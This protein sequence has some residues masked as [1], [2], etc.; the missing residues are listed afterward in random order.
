[1]NVQRFLTICEEGKHG[2]CFS[3]SWRPATFGGA[4]SSFGVSCTENGFDYINS[5]SAVSMIIAQDPAGTTPEKT[6]KLCMV[7]NSENQTDK[8]ARNIYGLWTAAVSLGPRGDRPPRYYD[9]NYSTNA[10]KHGVSGEQ[11]KYINKARRS[12]SAILQKEIGL[13]SPRVII[14]CGTM[15]AQS[16]YEIGLITTK[17]G[18]FRKNLGREVY[19]ET[20]NGIT[21]FCTYHPSARAMQTV[22]KLYSDENSYKTM[23]II[24]EKVAEHPEIEG[25]VNSF[26]EIYTDPRPHDK[27]MRVLLL[28]W[29]DIG[30]AI[31]EE[32]RELF[33]D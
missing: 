9:Q 1:M 12:C 10:I 7:C 33:G 20:A 18:G 26:L 29:I 8:T 3:C 13:L 14:A 11:R 17:W 2:S 31:R 19:R 27:A 24:K 23:N 15:A 4:E 25:S 16:L 32:Y 22:H 28:H 6:G 5:S 30:A 21:V